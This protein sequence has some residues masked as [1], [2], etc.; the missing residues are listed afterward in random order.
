LS[1]PTDF[2]HP[3]LVMAGASGERGAILNDL[4]ERVRRGERFAVGDSVEVQGVPL[5]FG[6]VHPAQAEQGLVNSWFHH[7]EAPERPTPEL[8]VL[9]VCPERCRCR[10]CG[11]RFDTPEWVLDEAG[12]SPGRSAR[13]SR[14]I[15]RAGARARARQ[16]RAAGRP[17]GTPG[18][19]PTTP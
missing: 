16:A 8:Q 4:G 1:H 19:R 14:A 10:T 3:E 11:L 2:D 17:G 9:Q 18:Y 5:S 12:G 15:R 13:P 6:Q 7:Y